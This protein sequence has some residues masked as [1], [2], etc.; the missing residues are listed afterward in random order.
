MMNI[1]K[2]DGF[3]SQKLFVQP[4]YML[5]ELGESELTR[6]LFISDI[7]SFPHAQ[8]HFRER[9]EGCPAHIFIYCAQGSGWVEYD[10]GQHTVVEQRQLAV[11]PAGTPHRYG[12]SADN[13][14]SIYWFHLQGDHA[15]QLI[16]FYG[17]DRGLLTLPLSAHAK[18][19]EDF[20]QCYSLLV[21]K[22]YSLPVQIHAANTMRHL[23]SSIGISAGGSL[24]DKKRERYLEQAL[25]YMTD[26]LADSVTLP[27]IARHTGLSKQHLI[28]LFNQETGCPPIEYFIRMKMQRASSLLDLTDLSIK[29]IAASV[30]FAD[31]YYF[32]RLFKKFIGCSPTEYRSIP[33]G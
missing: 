4:E 12:A 6:S 8:F 7:G 21:N 3:A 20:E 32:S 11:I 22:A 28:Y 29:E 18:M 19:L 9:K 26:R 10:G 23:L 13:P 27:D 30:G 17:L 31:P 2:P 14:W 24:Q 25:R 1:Q 15:S 5:K 16:R 33:K